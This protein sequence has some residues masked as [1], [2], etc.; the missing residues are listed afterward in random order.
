MKYCKAL[1]LT[2]VSDKKGMAVFS[3][4]H[5]VVNVPNIQVKEGTD[6]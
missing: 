6:I 3:R 4:D 2:H 5:E 1:K